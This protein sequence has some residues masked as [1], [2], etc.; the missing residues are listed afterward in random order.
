ME[1]IGA[2]PDL[3]SQTAFQVSEVLLP[4]AQITP[5]PVTATRRALMVDHQA[6]HRSRP[7]RSLPLAERSWLTTRRGTVEGSVH[8][9]TRRLMVSAGPRPATVGTGLPQSELRLPARSRSLA[10]SSYRARLSQLY[11]V[12]SIRE[13]GGLRFGLCL[14]V[15]AA[16]G[17]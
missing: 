8:C 16:R 14:H 6:W 7:G 13:C 2:I 9:Q 12:G 3:P 1:L 15:G 10:E 5:R 11:A 17:R 4:R